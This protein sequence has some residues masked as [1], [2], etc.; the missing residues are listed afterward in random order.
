MFS[1]RLTVYFCRDAPEGESPG[2]LHVCRIEGGH[3]RQERT[4]ADDLR[5]APYPLDASASE[6]PDQAFLIF[7]DSKIGHTHLLNLRTGKAEPI[8]PAMY[9]GW[10]LGP[11]PLAVT[12]E[13]RRTKDRSGGELRT[14]NVGAYDIQA[15][16]AVWT[17]PNLDAPLTDP[18]GRY[19]VYLKNGGDSRS[20]RDK[21][22]APALFVH[23][24]VTRRA[25]A[26]PLRDAVH[27]VGGWLPTYLQYFQRHDSLWLPYQTS[28]QE[29]GGRGIAFVVS[30]QTNA[31]GPQGP[32][33]VDMI[34]GYSVLCCIGANGYVRKF[35]TN[36]NPT[37]APVCW[38]RHGRYLFGSYWGDPVEKETYAVYGQS[39]ANLRLGIWD[40][41]T[42]HIAALRLPKGAGR[43]FAVVED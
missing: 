12:Y 8:A 25:H 30:I 9:V 2:P 27:L 38:A 11:R 23:D 1:S 42:G 15:Q 7:Q 37:F 22:P 19:I 36:L 3:I 10:T 17:E 39:P 33:T 43:V 13:D 16:K 41:H 14:V 35:R 34:G 21:A 32:S 28:L 18:A 20:G 29:P 4:L 31:E 24:V 26:L 40:T 5:P 6:S